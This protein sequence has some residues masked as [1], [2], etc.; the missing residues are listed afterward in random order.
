MIFHY[1][2]RGTRPY[3]RFAARTAVSVVKKQ[4]S[5]RHCL[6]LPRFPWG[7]TARCLLYR[8]LF[9]EEVNAGLVVLCQGKNLVEIF[10]KKKINQSPERL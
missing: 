4:P 10:G 8:C 9:L 2:V 3:F 1:P 6:P 7:K 5:F